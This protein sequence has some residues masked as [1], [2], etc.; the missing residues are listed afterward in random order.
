MDG[1]EFNVYVDFCGF[2]VYICNYLTIIDIRPLSDIE[3]M[4]ERTENKFS[5]DC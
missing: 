3:E 4:L 2:I 5:C 1:D